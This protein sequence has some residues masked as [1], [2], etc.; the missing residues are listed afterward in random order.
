MKKRI[1]RLSLVACAYIL[2]CPTIGWA[3]QGSGIAGIVQDPSGAVL[4]GVTVEAASPVLIEKTRAV[5]TDGQGRYSIIDLRRGTYAVTF[6]L[7]GFS[8]VVREGIELT[9]GFTATVNVEMRVGALEET[10]TVTGASPLV[11]VQNVRQQQV[12]SSD[13]LDSL[14]SSSKNLATLQNVIIGMSNSA[15]LSATNVGG[16][17]GDYRMSSQ[18]TDLFHGKLGGRTMF[19]GMR[20]QSTHSQGTLGYIQNPFTVEEM[21]VETGAAPAESA[22]GGIVINAIPKEGSNSFRFGINGLYTSTGLQSDNLT[23][24]LRERGVT[25]VGKIH[26]LYDVSGTVGGPVKK[27]TLWFFAAH[28]SAGNANQAPNL[29]YNKTQGTMF[30]TPDPS[31]P[32]VTDENSRSD[33]VRLTWQASS[34]NKLNF[35][36]DYQNLC[37]CMLYTDNTAVEAFGDNR[38]NPLGLYMVTWSSPLTSKLLFEAG[39]AAVISR[40]AFF[41]Q[42]GVDSDDIS[43]LNLQNGFRYNAQRFGAYR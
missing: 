1:T 4:P 21:V 33:A 23:D 29:F 35:F 28:R 9:A 37:V 25:T 26:Y 36:A 22:G 12:V 18:T 39:A 34:R 41:R 8:T 14:P 19:D 2:V 20:T 42:P 17:R 31:R 38:Y 40:L 24:E 10:V 5:V 6:S 11:D 15:A 32:A 30:Y 27:D 43:I 3:Q 13:L 16:T 7:P